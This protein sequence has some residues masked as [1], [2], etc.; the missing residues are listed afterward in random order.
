[1][2][3]YLTLDRVVR[4]HRQIL[5]QS[6]QA[7]GIRDLGLLESALAQPRM[8][9]GEADLYPTLIDKAATLGFSLVMNHP[10]V[11]GNK[12]IGHAA[13]ET[14][15][16]INDMEIVASVDEQEVTIQSLAAGSL[17]REAFTRWL[18]SRVKPRDRA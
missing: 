9:F 11:D 17:D 16:V 1:M 12:R 3:R 8:T 7:A 10:F 5:E 15:L 4:L 18:E 14:F 13:M 6:E 2:I